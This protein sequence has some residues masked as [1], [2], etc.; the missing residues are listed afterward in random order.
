M[1]PRRS[2]STAISNARARF[3][4][5]AA[6]ETAGIGMGSVLP[7]AGSRP[8]RLSASTEC[9]TLP[10]CAPASWSCPRSA[11]RPCWSPAGA[12]ETTAPPCVNRG[13]D[14]GGCRDVDD[15]GRAHRA[16]DAGH[17]DDECRSSQPR[18]SR[19]P[20]PVRSRS[21]WPSSRTDPCR[22]RSSIRASTA[23]RQGKQE[24]TYD[25][26][27]WLPP[28]EAAKVGQMATVDMHAYAG[29]ARR[30]G[31]RSLS[32][33]PVQPRPRRLPAAVDVPDDPPCV[34][35]LRGRGGR[36]SVSQPDRRVR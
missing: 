32:P 35:G 29:H 7:F 22:S 12:R 1:K 16:D 6:R 17:H 2:I 23:P 14:I 33:G 26:R 8:A 24:A 15:R 18:L 25:L 10:G 3:P 9:G 5:T 11:S 19:T 27:A 21:A 34:V 30:C 36:T 28:A 4:G 31:R 13:G 20:S